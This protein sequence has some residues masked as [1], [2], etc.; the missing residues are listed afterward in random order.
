MQ[1]P[2]AIRRVLQRH[3]GPVFDEQAADSQRPV[4]LFN[5]RAQYKRRFSLQE[6]FIQLVGLEL[7]P[8]LLISHNLIRRIR[9]KLNPLFRLGLGA[10]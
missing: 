4:G 1:G 2:T 6:L 7:Q 3:I 5:I 8:Q 10:Q 9:L